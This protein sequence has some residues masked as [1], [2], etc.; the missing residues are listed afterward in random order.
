MEGPPPMPD[1]GDTRQ[2]HVLTEGERMGVRDARLLLYLVRTGQLDTAVEFA[3]QEDS[4][5]WP[6]LER[7]ADRLEHADRVSQRKIRAWVEELK[8]WRERDE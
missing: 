6:D 3:A 1:L 8:Q 4:G 2:A 5:F 7:L